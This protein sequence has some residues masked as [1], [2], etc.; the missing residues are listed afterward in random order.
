MLS[1]ILITEIITQPVSLTTVIALEDVTLTCSASVDNITYSWHRVGGSVP[2][3]SIGQNNGTLTI[4]RIIPYDN[5]MYYCVAKKEEI[6]VESN[7]A[8]VK[9]NG[10]KSY[11]YKPLLT[12][13]NLLQI[14]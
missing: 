7:E 14:N 13:N 10:E 5:G 6:S 1:Y 4:P 8:L 3:K 12:F 2:S 9:V 11:W